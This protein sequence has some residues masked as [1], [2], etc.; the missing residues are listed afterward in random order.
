M[1]NVEI[2]DV[3]DSNNVSGRIGQRGVEAAYGE[4]TSCTPPPPPFPPPTPAT[5]PEGTG[6]PLSEVVSCN[7]TTSNEESHYGEVNLDTHDR[8]TFLDVKNVL[9]SLCRLVD[10]K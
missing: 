8:D 10:K 1:Q 5:W 4:A 9:D 6:L 2:I 7:A 3:Q